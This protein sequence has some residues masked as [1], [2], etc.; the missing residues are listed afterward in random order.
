MRRA[1][2][3]AEGADEAAPIEL[4]VGWLLEKHGMGILGKTPDVM[5]IMR[6]NK[7]TSIYRVFA[8]LTT[9][10]TRGMSSSEFAFIRDV[11]RE[12]E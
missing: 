8:K 3:V 5:L 10:G 4:Q 7:L 9:G 12:M 1:R 2:D 11:M 6:A